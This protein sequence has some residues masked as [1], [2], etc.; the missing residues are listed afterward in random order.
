MKHL[1]KGISHFG[2]TKVVKGAIALLIVAAGIFVFA[3]AMTQF[4]K[5]SWKA[6][7]VGV[8][9]MVA[10]GVGMALMGKLASHI[11]MGAVAL[12]IMSAGMWV[13]SKAMVNFTKVSWKAVGVAIVSLVALAVAVGVLGAIMMSGVG[14]AA[15]VLGAAA[16]II[17]AVAVGILGLALIL[18]GKGIKPLIPLFMFFGKIVMRMVDGLFDAFKY[19]IDKVIPI[20]K[21]VAKL[22]IDVIKGLGESIALVIDSISGGLATFLD[23]V[24]GLI[25]SIGNAIATPLRAIGDAIS[26]VAGAIGDAIIK[27]VNAVTDSFEKLSDGGMATGLTNTAMAIGK[28]TIALAGFMGVKIAGGLMASIGNAVGSVVDWVGSWFGGEK[29]PSIMT[30]LGALA[31]FPHKALLK[32]GP[33]LTKFKNSLQEFFNMSYDSDSVTETIS[34]IAG[35]AGAIRAFE[36]GNIGFFEGIGDALGSAFSAVGGWISGLFGGESRSSDPIDT[37]ERIFA[38]QGK[39]VSMGDALEKMTAGL[40]AVLAFGEGGF[41]AEGFV[42]LNK[43]LD[44][45]N[46]QQLNNL[47]NIFWR[48]TDSIKSSREEMSMF[49]GKIRLL[50][51]QLGKL[52]ENE[53][54]LVHIQKMLDAVN[55]VDTEK[56]QNVVQIVS[57]TPEQPQEEKQSIGGMLMN[58]ATLGQTDVL[59]DKI[60][61]H[62]QLKEEQFAIGQN[63]NTSG[64]Q[65][66]QANVVQNSTSNNTMLMPPQPRNN[67]PALATA[68]ARMWNN[69]IQ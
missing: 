62:A 1:A 65:I 50:D 11:I 25:E 27:V 36:N 16:L 23:S 58:I 45:I 32:T 33:A 2:A 17:I 21:I 24:G 52:V 47:A 31:T 60:N 57:T 44:S 15:I 53:A 39:V 18:F 19:L 10:L 35:L 43:V 51:N 8:V 64:Q 37:L 67:E 29:T 49:I 14:A 4:G 6:V 34:L 3:K 20:M 54:I 41:N 56:L 42:D 61:K 55:I 38:T 66:T 46:T 69:A 68:A 26:V 12:L 28:L 9:S 22:I 13:L 63:Q 7:A 59:L 40:Y 5:V 30:I 48:I